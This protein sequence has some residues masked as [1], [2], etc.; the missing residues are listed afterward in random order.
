MSDGSAPSTSVVHHSRNVTA[1]SVQTPPG[2][3][4]RT[5]NEIVGSSVQP[6]PT[7]TLTGGWRNVTWTQLIPCRNTALDGMLATDRRAVPC[8]PVASKQARTRNRSPKREA[9]GWTWAAAR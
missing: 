8:V 5:S 1:E 3:A 2:F 4:P 7:D 9:Y 6:R